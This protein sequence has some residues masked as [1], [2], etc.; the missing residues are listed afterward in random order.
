MGEAAR[1]H[2]GPAGLAH[3]LP[4]LPPREPSVHALRRTSLSGKFLF[5]R[6]A[7]APATPV[8]MPPADC[9]RADQ[10]LAAAAASPGA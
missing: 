7:P 3:R 9:A 2:R 4:L 10:G 5:S 8:A 1:P 6:S